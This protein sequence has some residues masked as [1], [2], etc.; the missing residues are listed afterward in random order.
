MKRRPVG[1]IFLELEI[2]I[3]ELIDSHDFQWGDILW[4]VFGHLKIH[5]PDAQEGYIDGGN[6]EFHYGA[7][8]D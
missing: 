4:W 3:D 2:L 7:K 1:K 5:R 6:P 8:D